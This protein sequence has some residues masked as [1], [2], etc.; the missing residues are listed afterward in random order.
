MSACNDTLLP[1][2]QVFPDA[3]TKS[4]FFDAVLSPDEIVKCNVELD[5]LLGDFPRVQSPPL[6]LLER[7]FLL[8]SVMEIYFIFS[9]LLDNPQLLGWSS[10]Y[11]ECLDTCRRVY[12]RYRD[13]PDFN[14]KPRTVQLVL[15]EDH[16]LFFSLK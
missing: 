12:L 7:S 6:T 8:L 10:T 1:V 13:N 2:S 3:E 9:V 5:K 4:I 15:Q 11:A 14:T 16:D